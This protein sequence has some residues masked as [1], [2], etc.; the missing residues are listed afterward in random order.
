MK[1]VVVLGGSSELGGHADR[2]APLDAG[3]GG[4]AGIGLYMEAVL[5]KQQTA[6]TLNYIKML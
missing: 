1:A 3:V 4:A 5:L 2:T 6:F